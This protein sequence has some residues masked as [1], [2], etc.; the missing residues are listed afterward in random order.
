M[1]T[2]SYSGSCGNCSRAASL[3]DEHKTFSAKRDCVGCCRKKHLS[4]S[5]DQINREEDSLHVGVEILE[6]I[7]EV[8][9]LASPSA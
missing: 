1:M 6:C 3:I 2:L 7:R 4:A 8:A 5:Q 9:L